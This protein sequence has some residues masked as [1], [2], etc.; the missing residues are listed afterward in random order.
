MHFGF[1]LDLPD[2]DLLNADLL[3][4]R[5]THLDLFV[6]KMSWRRL[7]DMSSRRF[8]DI[9]WRRVP[10]LSSKRLKDQQMFAGILP[11]WDST[12]VFGNAIVNAVLCWFYDDK[13]YRRKGFHLCGLSF[14]VSQ[15]CW[16]NFYGSRNEGRLW[17]EN[18]MGFSRIF[19]HCT[20]EWLHP[21]FLL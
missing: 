9:S 17:N 15:C 8:H 4:Q 6:S 18:L 21:M 11:P 19:F 3:D 2:I 20:L 10:D 7:Q 16:N 12:A 5:Y 13:K 14:Q 1:V